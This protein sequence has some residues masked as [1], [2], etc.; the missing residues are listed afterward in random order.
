MSLF[1]FLLFS[2]YL[3]EQRASFGIP[4]KQLEW[5]GKR[6]KKQT[7]NKEIKENSLRK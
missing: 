6:K 5:D 1:D 2:L 7:E 4:E 3:N